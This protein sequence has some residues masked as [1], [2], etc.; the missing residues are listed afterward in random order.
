M[1]LRFPRNSAMLSGCSEFPNYHI[2]VK[3]F[4]MSPL[5]GLSSFILCIFLFFSPHQ[6]RP[7]G[8]ISI[9]RRNFSTSNLSISTAMLA[10][11]ALLVSL[12]SRLTS[13]D[14][15]RLLHMAII[16]DIAAKRIVATANTIEKISYVV[17]SGIFMRF[18]KGNGECMTRYLLYLGSI[19]DYI[20]YKAYSTVQFQDVPC[21]I[22]ML[23]LHW[24]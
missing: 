1:R 5:F 4:S 21:N 17:N 3:F 15:C 24:V 20:H 10:R 9:E 12:I 2:F 6:L 8:E 22:C 23:L 14:V 13:F 7:G 16:T 18:L 19:W 11:V